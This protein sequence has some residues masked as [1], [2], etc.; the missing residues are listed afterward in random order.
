MKLETAAIDTELIRN[1]LRV[2]DAA[3]IMRTERTSNDRFIFEQQPRERFEI[4][5][6]LWLL[7]INRTTPAVLSRFYCF[8]VP[9]C[10]FYQPH[11]ETRPA[12]ATP[13][14]QIAQI[15]FGV[16]QVCLDDN[17]GVRPIFKFLIGENSFEK[18]DRNIFVRVAFHVEVDKGAEFSS[19]AQN[20]PQLRCQMRNGISR[21]GRR[22]LRIERRN[23]D[24]DIYNGEKV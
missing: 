1:R 23:F 17:P 22:N 11:R 15:D 20:R 9:I 12:C 10:A 21:I 5:V 7:R 13:L 24:R 8:V 19:A 16:S 4:R 3:H 18:L 14:D 2:R 6:A